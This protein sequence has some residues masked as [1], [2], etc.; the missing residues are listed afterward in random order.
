[1]ALP[2]VEYPIYEFYVKSLDKKVKFRPFLVKEEKILLM[3][4][5]GKDAES[6]RQAVEQIIQNCAIDPI[7]VNELP[8]FDIEMIFLQ[9]RAKSVGE[10]VKLTFNCQNEVGDQPCN[11]NTDYV[12][13]L[14]K[15]H[16]EIQEG[17][18]PKIMINDKLGIKLKYPTLNNI[19]L[20]TTTNEYELMLRS[21]MSNIE[22]VYDAESVY[23]LS[24]CT[25]EEQI[26]FIESLSREVMENIEGFFR[27]AP[28]VVLRDK[29]LCTKCGFEHIL[30]AENLLDFFI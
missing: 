30:Y 21:L 22:S 8:M 12:L 6:I 17:H 1:M 23:K 2:K 24:D 20:L 7:D 15:I 3:A 16:Y 27:T 19:P 10:S 4:K 9:L 14:E 25:A 26:E 29:V 5:E 11:A 13:N 18:N 28:K